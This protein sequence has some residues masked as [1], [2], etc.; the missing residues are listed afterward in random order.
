MAYDLEKSDKRGSFAAMGLASEYTELC[1]QM[2]AG[3]KALGKI[4]EGGS[5]ERHLDN[6]RAAVAA[7]RRV[8]R[9]INMPPPLLSAFATA[10]DEP[11]AENLAAFFAAE[12]SPL[13]PVAVSVSVPMQATA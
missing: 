11:S 3:E 6:V 12:N 10:V 4:A 1:D 2:H 13:S 8:G 5:V 9:I 7:F